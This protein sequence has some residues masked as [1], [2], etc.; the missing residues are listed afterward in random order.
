M[1]LLSSALCIS[2]LM[3]PTWAFSETVA[4]KT[5][6]QQSD[7]QARNQ[8][9]ISEFAAGLQ[10]K[11]GQALIDLADEISSTAIVTPELTA[12]L[13]SL[14]E[15]LLEEQILNGDK[16][17]AN[18]LNSVMRAY[19][20][21]GASSEAKSLIQRTLDTSTSRGV[22]NRALR[23]LPKLD[24]YAKRNQIASDA[25]YYKPEQKI[26]THRLLGWLADSDPTLQR[27]AMEEIGRNGGAEKAVYELIAK[28]LD[29]NRYW[30][31]GGNELDAIAWMAKTLSNYARSDYKELLTSI[32]QDKKVNKKVKKYTNP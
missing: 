21:M 8:A 30:N 25:T 12:R 20:S 22:R 9:I 28:K 3:V 13:K 10:T 27:Y 26:E 11:R 31:T 7:L 18:E 16:T 1:K 14:T 15:S 17:V 23:L 2:L 5:E 32:K 29:E 4:P 6:L 19:A 24:W